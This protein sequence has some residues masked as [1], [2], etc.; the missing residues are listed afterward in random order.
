MAHLFIVNPL[1]GPGMDN[2]FSTHPDTGNRIAALMELAE[3]MGISGGGTVPE[4]TG[5]DPYA[6][7]DD[8]Y[9]RSDDE[10]T[11]SG[12]WSKAGSGRTRRRGPWE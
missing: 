11:S 3:E 7:P 2:L 6:R 4:A 9:R 8:Y 5:S 12:P 10:A 1:T